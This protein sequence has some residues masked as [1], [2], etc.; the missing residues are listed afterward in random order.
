MS[1]MRARERGQTRTVLLV[2]DEVRADITFPDYFFTTKAEKMV[3]NNNK[4]VGK[5]NTF[6]SLRFVVPAAVFS[7]FFLFARAFRPLPV[8]SV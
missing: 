4:K 5:E 2:C 7:F 6:S 8:R 1:A 3:P